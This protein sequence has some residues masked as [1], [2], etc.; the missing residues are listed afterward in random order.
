MDTFPARRMRDAIGITASGSQDDVGYSRLALLQ[1]SLVSRVYTSFNWNEVDFDAP[2]RLTAT[3]RDR[4]RAYLGAMKARKLR[5]HIMLMANDGAPCPSRRVPI[6]I[7]ALALAGARAIKIDP[8]A[9]SQI[10]PGRTGLDADGKQAG[11][12][13]T[14]AAPDGTLT[15]SKPLPKEL[16]AGL[17]D[18][19]V[20]RFA[21]FQRPIRA[22]GS[23]NPIFE[24]TLR[25]WGDFVSAVVTEARAA[26]GDAFDLEIWNELTGGSQFLDANS[27]HE[28][29]IDDGPGPR[30]DSASRAVLERSRDVFRAANLP[31]ARLC[32]GFSNMRWTDAGSNLV[33][34]VPAFSRH[35]ALHGAAFPRDAAT[36]VLPAVRADGRPNGSL[37]PDGKW[38]EDF[39][40]RYIAAFPEQELTP[41]LLARPIF[42]D[43]S[44]VVSSDAAGVAHGRNTRAESGM[45]PAVW[46]S[47][48]NLSPSSSLIDFGKPSTAAA[49]ADLWRFKIKSSLRAMSAYVGKGV[50]EFIFYQGGSTVIDLVDEADTISGGPVLRAIRRFLTPFQGPDTIDRPRSIT[51]E[52]VGGC[53]QGTQFD[54]G[55]SAQFPPLY[56]GQ[57]VAFFPFQVDAD[58]F[59]AP[60]YVMTRNLSRLYRPEAPVTDVTRYDL[61]AETFTLTLGGLVAASPQMELQDPISGDVTPIT[62]KR[63]GAWV[64]V[65]VPLTDYPK[66]LVITDR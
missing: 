61:P 6:K 42:L 57:V 23:A 55:G 10:V 59:V 63:S 3:A 50:E 34:G 52:T 20:L 37:G 2:A 8:A 47:S 11:I 58:R 60:T 51:L 16:T 12:L 56:D 44:P 24:D 15:L 19:T 45:P 66:L 35:L 18:A 46:V 28:Q 30:F 36:A 40:P 43:L 32:S 54:G 62:G 53:R 31:G 33:A 48:F 22:D 38:R 17:R 49:E 9:L 27:Y 26:V 14:T 21:P 29:P 64:K 65:D 7:T 39:T 25:G 13:F 1:E 41:V 4:A 5:P